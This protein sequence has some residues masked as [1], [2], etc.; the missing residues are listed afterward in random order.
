MNATP[1]TIATQM[2][3]LNRNGSLSSWPGAQG[4]GKC[5]LTRI[6]AASP[7]R[8]PRDSVRIG[9]KDAAEIMTGARNSMAKGFSRPPVRNSRADSC[10][11]S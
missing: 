6:V 1:R 4:R 3:A 5:Q 2:P 8:T 9:D 10:R 11:R 7:V